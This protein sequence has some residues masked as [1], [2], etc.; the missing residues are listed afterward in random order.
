MDFGIPS[1]SAQY[2]LCRNSGF[3]GNTGKDSEKF[4]GRPHF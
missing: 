3:G 1:A 4:V 2:F